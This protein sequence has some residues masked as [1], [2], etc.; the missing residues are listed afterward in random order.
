M[1]FNIFTSSVESVTHTYM[2]VFMQT[3]MNIGYFSRFKCNLKDIFGAYID[4]QIWNLKRETNNA[5]VPPP[6]PPLFLPLFYPT[7]PTNILINK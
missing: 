5:L 6:P 3:T 4:F 2:I 7:F 1:G